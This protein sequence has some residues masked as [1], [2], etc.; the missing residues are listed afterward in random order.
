MKLANETIEKLNEDRAAKA[1]NKEPKLLKQ[2]TK[3]SNPWQILDWTLLDTLVRNHNSNGTNPYKALP[4]AIAQAT[5]RGVLQDFYSYKKSLKEYYKNPKKFTGRP[6]LP[7]Y[8]ERDENNTFKIP[9]KFISNGKLPKISKKKIFK[10]YDET[11]VLETKEKEAYHNINLE[12]EIE[13]IKKRLKLPIDAKPAVVK[14]S[15]KKKEPKASIIFTY[16]Q[17]VREESLLEK[18]LQKAELSAP[19]TKAS[20]NIAITKILQ[21]LNPIEI[22]KFSSIDL[23]INNFLSLT[24]SEGSGHKIISNKRLEDKNNHFNKLYDQRLSEL[25]IQE[26]KELQ[27]KETTEKLSRNESIRKKQLYKVVYSG[28]K[29][30]KIISDRDNWFKDA[31]NKIASGI[32]KILTENKSELLIVGL[33]QKWKQES[34]MGKKQNRRFHNTAHTKFLQILRNQCT[35]AS[36]VLITTEESY[37]SK[38]SFANNQ[39]LKTHE[40]K[41]TKPKPESI[42]LVEAKKS[43]PTPAMGIPDKLGYRSTN[44]HCYVNKPHLNSQFKNWRKKVHADINGALN[45][46][47]K[48]F[49]WFTFNDKINFN[50]TLLWLSPK[51]GLTPMHT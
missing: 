25:I 7:N 48:I 51:T 2:F 13:V 21:E 47:R 9:F 15:F 46:G 26:L 28:P 14:I 12:Q 27:A 3:E 8:K 6:M 35:K 49:S 37:T 50:Y 4:S 45:I 18:I 38:S 24:F 33:N 32:I 23:G 29:L 19:S 43:P 30:K 34:N 10:G 22:G 11:E 1:Q 41:Q 39:P 36:I 20:E 5:V 16:K 44:R 17:E 42:K 31:L 40:V